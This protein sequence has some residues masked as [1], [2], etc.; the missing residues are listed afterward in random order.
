MRTQVL[1]VGAGPVG[2]TAAMDLAWRGIEAVVVEIR[3]RGEAPNVK[4]N[5]VAARSMEIFRRLGVAPA[6][7]AT[8]LPED[9]ANDVSYRTTTLGTELA[10]I[11]IPCR[12]DRYSD[13]SGPDG[14]WPTPEPP[15]RINQI[16][17]E[18]VLFAHAEAMAGITI[19][20]RT[21]LEGFEQDGHG[22]TAVV[23]DLDSGATRTIRAAYLIGCD[24]AR[25][26]VRRAIGAM[27]QG[28]AVVQ[29]VQSTYIRAPGLLGLIPD[30]PAWVMFSLNPDRKSTRLNSSHG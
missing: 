8:G 10:R 15:H 5:H 16:F 17:L 12:R 28:D 25:S 13:R 3:H 22:V 27:F 6:L 26:Q 9:Y 30:R 2:L 19:L 14:W 18:P 11:H 23:R 1:V 4:C 24:G 20:N 21:S 29:R 7:R